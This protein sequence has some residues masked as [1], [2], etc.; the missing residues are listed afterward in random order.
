V[1]PQAAGGG[2]AERGAHPL[3]AGEERV[4]HGLVDG[5]GPGFLAGQEFIERGLT[6]SVRVARK[7][8]QI[9]LGFADMRV[10]FRKRPPN[11]ASFKGIFLIAFDA[12]AIRIPSSGFQN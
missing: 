6:V 9:E 12:R 4:A 8:L 2:E 7:L 10:C 5:G 3:A 11:G 1:P